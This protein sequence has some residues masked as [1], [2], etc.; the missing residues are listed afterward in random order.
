MDELA[1][2][3]LRHPSKSSAGAGLLARMDVQMPD[4]GR[5]AEGVHQENLKLRE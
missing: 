3:Y 2:K 5:G 4:D 1:G